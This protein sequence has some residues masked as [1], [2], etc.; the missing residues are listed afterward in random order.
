MEETAQERPL[1]TFA[2]FAYNQEEYIRE[3]IEGAFSQTY[4]PLEIILSDDCS[5]DRTYEI[6]QEMAAN[7][8]GPHKLR[9]RRNDINQGL[10][11]HINVLL[12]N[13]SGEYISWIGGDDVALQNKVEELIR[14]ILYDEEVVGVHSPFIEINE[15]GEFIKVKV[16][17]KEKENISLNKV[18]SECASVISQSHLFK[19]SVFHQFGPFLSD[20]KNEGPAISFR[21]LYY[22]KIAYVSIP[23]TKYR[24]GSGIST[25]RGTD[26]RVLQSIEPIKVA[27]WRLSAYRQILS[28]LRHTNL[29][30]IYGCKVSKKIIFYQNLININSKKKIVRSLI[31]NTALNPKDFS[32]LRAV[33]R[34]LSPQAFYKLLK[35]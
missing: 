11:N 8:V 18:I 32:T 2:L 12:E 6:M 5:T 29:Y 21:E 1:V 24:I 30:D 28:D 23:L 17:R 19:C 14:P 31:E 10:A 26:I 33:I 16:S 35:T 34:I 3:A 7:Y 13:A 27:E 4:E 9:V 25:Y 20:L 15:V 22:G